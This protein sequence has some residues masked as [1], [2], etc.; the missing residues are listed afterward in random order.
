MNK[1]LDDA[2]KFIDS[3]LDTDVLEQNLRNIV[4]SVLSKT[5]TS[6]DATIQELEVNVAKEFDKFGCKLNEAR[7]RVDKLE[8][9]CRR[10][11]A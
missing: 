8:R 4:K 3:E 5:I 11:S 7:K 10:A 9:D 2:Q 6:V 1:E